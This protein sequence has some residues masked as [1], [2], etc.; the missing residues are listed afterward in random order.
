MPKIEEH[1][2]EIPGYTLTRRG[3]LIPIP[4]HANHEGELS[5]GVFLSSVHCRLWDSGEWFFYSGGY[6]EPNLLP[7]M[8]KLARL[9]VKNHPTYRHL[10]T[11]FDNLKKAR[12][13][14]QGALGHY[15]P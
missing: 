14:E 6:H 13:L 15:L 5:K 8:R 4:A 11:V 2:R 7:L 1:S 10:P 3:Q 12:T 9:M